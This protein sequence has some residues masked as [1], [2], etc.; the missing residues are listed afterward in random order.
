[1]ETLTHWKKLRN[2]DY[3]GAYA[4]PN[5]GAEMILTIAFARKES[6][7]GTDGKKQD[8]LVVH[9]KEAEKP[10]IINATNAKTISRL[11][12]SNF[13]EKWQGCAV[14]VY[15]AKVSAFGQETDALRIRSYSPQIKAQPE[16]IDVS[17]YIDSLMKADSLDSLKTAF[18]AM[19]ESVRADKKVR[20]AVN[21]RAEQF[22]ENA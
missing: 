3:L 20:E 10:M 7:A 6:V 21:K 8:C 12:K 9:W 22:D 1:M 4:L 11:A 5:E 2:P 19:P 15:A 14:I 18:Q 17:S 16:Q 13:I